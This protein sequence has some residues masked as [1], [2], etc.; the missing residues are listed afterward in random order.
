MKKAVIVVLILLLSFSMVCA[1]E[2]QIEYPSSFLFGLYTSEDGASYFVFK[3]EKIIVC[4][5]GDQRTYLPKQIEVRKTTDAPLQFDFSGGDLF[6][7]ERIKA[8]QYKVYISVGGKYKY[9]QIFT[10]KY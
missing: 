4:L 1:A 7:F 10:L 8:G 3:P 5:N 2:S 6:N 9:L